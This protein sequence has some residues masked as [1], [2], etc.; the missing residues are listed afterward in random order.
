MRLIIPVTLECQAARQPSERL[1][2]RYDEYKETVQLD[3]E[4]EAKDDPLRWSR[5]SKFGNLKFRGE[6]IF[7]F[8]FEKL[9]RPTWR[10]R[11]FETKTDGG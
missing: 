3:S 10:A 2:I 1:G 9:R 4:F 11:T 5:I 8:G 6:K 7:G